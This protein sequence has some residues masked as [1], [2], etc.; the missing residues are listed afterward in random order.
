MGT[1]NLERIR[2]AQAA[3][4]RLEHDLQTVESVLETVGDIA[5]SVEEARESVK[6]IERETRRWLP[7]I[8]L[9]GVLLVLA[10]VIVRKVRQSRQASQVEEPLQGEPAGSPPPP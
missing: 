3:T 8:L 5:E 10:A 7:R 1:T 6:E 4:T 9:I 2:A